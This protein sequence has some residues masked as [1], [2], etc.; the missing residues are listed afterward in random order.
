MIFWCISS[1]LPCCN[2]LSKM[3]KPHIWW[4]A[5]FGNPVLG[6]HWG[7]W[8]VYMALAWLSLIV[9]LFFGLLKP[10]D[11]AHDMDFFH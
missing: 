4:S 11:A 10:S 8:S 9:L 7:P 1:L 2:S 5:Q 3:L 6:T